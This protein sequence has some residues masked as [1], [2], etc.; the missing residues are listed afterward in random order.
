MYEYCGIIS[1]T[2]N[3]GIFSM[4]WGRLSSLPPGQA[5]K[6]APHTIAPAY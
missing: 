1:P 4:L 5:R 6:P 2:M 3:K